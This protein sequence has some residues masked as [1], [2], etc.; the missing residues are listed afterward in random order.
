MSIIKQRIKFNEQDL[1]IKFPLN[2]YDSFVGYQQEIDSLTQVTGIDLINPVIDGEIYRFIYNKSISDTTIQFYFLQNDLLQLNF[3][4]NLVSNINNTTYNDMTL[5]SFFILDFYDTYDINKQRKIFT[6]YLTKIL[7]GEKSGIVPLPK[8]IISPTKKNQLYYWNVPL[9]YIN[10]ITGSSI[11]N[12]YV[13]FSFYS[14]AEG[15]V[16]LYYNYDNRM[17]KTPEKLFVKAELNLSNR[18][19]RFLTPTYTIKLYQLNETTDNMFEEK[20]N[21][22]IEKFDLKKQIFPPNNVFDYQTGVY[23]S[24][25]TT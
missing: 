11:V 4:T 22:A 24:G 23:I 19:W 3:F 20:V 10:S 18:M 7:E 1:F 17:L 8:Y 12:C 25:A 14:A 6:T 16:L 5:N 21:N 13:K 2:I 9:S 15:K